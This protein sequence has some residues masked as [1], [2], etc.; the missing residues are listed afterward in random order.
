MRELGTTTGRWMVAA[1]AG[2][3]LLASAPAG[4]AE[5]EHV[6]LQDT[7]FVPAEVRIAP[8]DA[9]RWTYQSGGNHTLTFRDG[10][11]YHE[12]CPGSLGTLLADCFSQGDP[13]IERTFP[14]AGTFEYYCKIHAGMAGV[15]IVAP[16]PSTAAPTTVTTQ[17]P[18]TTTTT[19]AT[20]TTTRVLA[21]S[22]TTASSTTTTTAAGGTST[23]I[24]PNEPPEFD[25]D[26]DG[27]SES[28]DAGEAVSASDGAG[29]SGAV[30]L[31]VAL[32]LIVAAGG[33]FLLWRLRPGG[34]PAE[35]P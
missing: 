22:S 29:N 5:V 8:N 33:G 21:T 3:G 26:D 24:T 17:A 14:D 30:G 20:T 11:D 2:L 23:T 6:A 31:I 27:G 13:P 18:R 28:A 16:T 15:V 12:D 1:A 35:T 25:P 34:G 32:L 19:R 7:R 9:V 10:T 4:A